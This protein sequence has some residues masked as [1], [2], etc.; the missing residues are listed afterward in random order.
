MNLISDL[1]PFSESKLRPN[2]K[3][4]AQRI[5]LVNS[6]KENGIKHQKREVYIGPV[7]ETHTDSYLITLIYAIQIAE[8]LKLGKEEKARIKAEH[9]IRDDFTIE[10]YEIIALLCELVHERM[11]HLLSQ[12]ECPPDLLDTVATIL[13]AAP[14]CQISEMVVVEKQFIKRFGKKF[15]EEVLKK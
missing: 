10:A 7:I 5:Q 3:M 2:L 4:A 15:A 12:E 8:L 9:L 1:M 6:K 14:R 13:Y 11:K